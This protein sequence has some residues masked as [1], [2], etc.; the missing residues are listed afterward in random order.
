MADRTDVVIVSAVRTP[1]GIY[2]GSLRAYDYYELG[3]I[4][5]T[6]ILSRV[7]LSPDIVKNKR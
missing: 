2:G 4:P 1:F 3:A 5:I 6:E 7:S